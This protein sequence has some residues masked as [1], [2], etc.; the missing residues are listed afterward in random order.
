MRKKLAMAALIL[1][2][3]LAVP[4]VLGSCS[5]DSDAADVAGDSL[6]LTGDVEIPEGGYL[7]DAGS[8]LT[9]GSNFV[10]TGDGTAI[11]LEAGST[12]A[13]MGTSAVIMNKVQVI[14]DGS[15]SMKSDIDLKNMDITVDLSIDGDIQVKMFGIVGGVESETLSLDIDSL[16]MDA[17]PSDS[18]IE[19]DMNANIPSA[20][21]RSETS[22]LTAKDVSF[23]VKADIIPPSVIEDVSD[24]QMTPVLQGT[25]AAE[26]SV[27]SVSIESTYDDSHQDSLEIGKISAS[28]DV[29]Y[30]GA[31][32]YSLDM[33]AS[34][35]SFSYKQDYSDSDLQYSSSTDISA[36]GV[37]ANVSVVSSIDGTNAGVD[38]AGM[39]TFD[40]VVGDFDYNRKSQ[41]QGSGSEDAFVVSDLKA[42]GQV[43]YSMSATDIVLSDQSSS[44]KLSLGSGYYLESTTDSDGNMLGNEATL[45]N[46]NLT[47]TMDM[48]L[49][50][51]SQTGVVLA[52]D[53]AV[54]PDMGYAFYSGTIAVDGRVGYLDMKTDGMTMFHMENADISLEKTY[55]EGDSTSLSVSIEGGKIAY[56]IGEAD[57]EFRDAD[58]EVNE[59]IGKRETSIVAERAIKSFVDEEGN[60]VKEYYVD[61]TGSND[62]EPIGTQVDGFEEPLDS[63]VIYAAIAVI[64]IVV[65]AAAAV[66]LRKR[67][68]AGEA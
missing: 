67:K 23:S 26:F 17:V 65:I 6:E 66:L 51:G 33:K 12:V 11:T 43:S 30:K 1:A 49:K 64:A 41:Y 2:V 27:G 20:T 31:T 22:V 15:V 57:W 37:S 50:A 9:V 52:E 56:H 60:P 28:I 4:F 55:E 21:L 39:V 44:I 18:G 46:I 3:M 25:I 48:T 42:E 59:S 8:T 34:M 38:Y 10:L 45:K 35:G 14:V 7:I 40:A 68:G 19:I 36:S 63:I 47:L 13:F 16:S 54:V 5:D 29:S 24:A 61:V 62:A 53:G 58:L 32:D